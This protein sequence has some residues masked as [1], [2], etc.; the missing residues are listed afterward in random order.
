MLL[1]LVTF[2]LTAAGAYTYQSIFSNVETMLGQKL[3]HIARTAV[4]LID[5][6]DHQKIEDALMAQ[7]ENVTD[8]D[9]FKRIQKTL[10]NIKKSNELTEEI[11][12]VI[13]P[14]WAEGN[15]IFMSMSNEK[16]Y[17]GNSIKL[18]AGVA[19][20]LATGKPKYSKIYSD[21]EGVWVSAFAPILNSEGKAIAAF[22]VDYHA[23]REIAAARKQLLQSIG[24][25]AV[26]AIFLSLI[27]G[28]IIG[29]ILSRP[30]LKLN[31]AATQVSAGNLDVLVENKSEDEIGVLSR[32]FNL[33]VEDLKSSKIKLE[34]Y[35]RNLEL[36]VEERTQKLAVAMNANT[37]LLNNLGQGFMIIKKDG[38]IAPGSTK[39][40]SAFFGTEPSEKD[41]S[42]LL[43]L[44]IEETESI[45]DWID[46]CFSEVVAFDSLKELGPKAFEKIDGRYVELSYR[47]IYSDDEKIVEIICI[48]E[49]KTKERNLERKAYEEKEYSL[50]ILNLIKDR[51]QFHDFVA[52]TFSGLEKLRKEIA[53]YTTTKS[54]DVD[55]LFR[56]FHTAKGEAACFHVL[57]LKENAHVAE[58][59][60]A[61]LNGNNLQIEEFKLE[62]DKACL[63]MQT[64]L[65]QF[66]TENAEVIGSAVEN[67]FQSKT[68][69]T[70][71]LQ[72]LDQKLKAILG[73]ESSEYRFFVETLLVEDIA[74]SFDKYKKVSL[75]LALQQNKSIQFHIEKDKVHLSI[76]EF[77]P[78]I[79]SCVHLFRNVVDHGIETADQ[80]FEAN[81]PE[82]AQVWLKFDEIVNGSSKKIRICLE[83][84]GRGVNPDVIRSKLVSKGLKSES[85]LSGL[86]DHDIIQMIFLPQFSSLNSVT[87]IS[88]RGVGLDAISTEVIKLGGQVWVESQVGK[89]SKFIIEIPLLGHSLSVA[90]AS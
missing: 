3:D 47:P 59:V 11:Y 71:S 34:D 69:N 48:A 53:A 23:E 83:G 37:T 70:E 40:A 1:S 30:I 51:A 61:Q 2:C 80:R 24:V 20:A 8:Q 58:N 67:G 14:D 62:L 21:S 31:Q 50:F 60:L 43:Q 22:E 77:K 26:V 5:P 73:E 55:G 12:T 90:K 65:K 84:D 25:P 57:G 38:S 19:E 68:I 27:F 52:T 16:T 10:Q 86:H 39:A 75:D 36:K 17:V 28:N 9:Y 66:V 56:F 63:A 49:D 7:E 87:S 88:G 45:K 18:Q 85:E 72:K 44:N 54:V 46:L 76:D 32:V 4:L 82:T 13:A 41:F 6:A 35:A 74:N 79:S 29:K 64:S 89:G 42:V 81:K 33:M 15:M 78:L